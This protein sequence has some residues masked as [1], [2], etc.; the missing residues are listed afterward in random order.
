MRLALAAGCPDQVDALAA[1]LSSRQVTE[2]QAFEA[3][4]GGLGARSFWESMAQFVSMWANAHRDPK[5]KA[6]P[7]KP[8]D[9]LPWLQGTGPAM[10]QRAFRAT[11][12]P[13]KVVKRK[14]G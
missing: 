9:F 14:K 2:W 10:T 4:E 11:F 6:T 7:F 13:V 3:I 1:A 12:G 8:A 5:K